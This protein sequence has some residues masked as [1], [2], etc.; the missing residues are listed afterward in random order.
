MLDI[1]QKKQSKEV[2]EGEEKVTSSENKVNELM[3]GKT[4]LLHHLHVCTSAFC[5]QRLCRDICPHSQL[6]CCQLVTAVDT[7]LM[8]SQICVFAE[9]EKARKDLATMK[10]Q[11]E[12]TNAEYD[13]LLAE[14]AKLQVL[15]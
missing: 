8:T 13:R 12:S 3:G 1:L 9:L 11:A 7:T 4:T 10:K 6:L 15:N 14:H 2:Q 5:C